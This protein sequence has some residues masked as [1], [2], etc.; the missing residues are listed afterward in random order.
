[1]VQFYQL[2]MSLHHPRGAVDEAHG[3]FAVDWDLWKVSVLV[4]YVGS[5]ESM[6]LV[7]FILLIA[8]AQGRNQKVN[9][10]T[11]SLSHSP[12]K[13]PVPVRT[14]CMNAWWD[15]CKTDLNSFPRRKLDETTGTSSYYMDE[16]H[17]A[18]SEIQR[19]QYGRRS[20]L[21]SEPSALET[22]VHLRRYAL[23]V[24]FA[25]NDDDD[26]IAMMLSG[27]RRQAV[28]QNNSIF[29][30]KMWWENRENVLTWSPKIPF[31]T[32]FRICSAYCLMVFTV[33]FS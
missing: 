14:H 12:V 21:G 7:H 13:A 6:S 32:F 17:S 2:Q 16:N 29:V 18:G 22:D 20:W 27:L 23:L 4:N 33:C 3:A 28:V 1:M 26:D 10:A 15:R 30:L 31:V 19:P 5:L 25:R 8:C 24:V 9:Q 11:P